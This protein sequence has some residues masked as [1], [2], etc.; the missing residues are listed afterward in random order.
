MFDKNNQK[1]IKSI[2][3]ENTNANVHK[4]PM[5]SM[6]TIGLAHKIFSKFGNNAE[7]IKGVSAIIDMMKIQ[8]NCIV[9]EV[10]NGKLLTFGENGGQD[11]PTTED[12]EE[13]DWVRIFSDVSVEE[14]NQ[15]INQFET[16]F[17]D[18]PY[19][20]MSADTLKIFEQFSDQYDIENTCLGFDTDDV[21][22]DDY[23]ECEGCPYEPDDEGKVIVEHD[24]ES[25]NITASYLHN[26]DDYTITI[27]NDLAFGV[28]KVR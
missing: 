18:K 4:V 2:K 16:K 12:T 24:C 9:L 5:V 14:L 20:I 17:N 22:C 1:N 27:D 13:R 7:A 11:V 25:G 6:D 23:D 28:V 10:L 21:D 3:D 26:D 8:D 19:L 15:A